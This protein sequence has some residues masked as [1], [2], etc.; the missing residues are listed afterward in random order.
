MQIGLE[1]S[2]WS[3]YVLV[4]I[5]LLKNL[6]GTN[7]VCTKSQPML[8]KDEYH[9]IDM[10]LHSLLCHAECVSLSLLSCLSKHSVAKLCQK[11]AWH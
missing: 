2:L 9:S 8:G 7:F 5:K 4:N 11:L 3:F 6:E 10:H 1:S